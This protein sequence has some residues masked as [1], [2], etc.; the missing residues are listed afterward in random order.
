M[1]FE[2][3]RV[4]NLILFNI[5]NIN[6]AFNLSRK[7]DLYLFKPYYLILTSVTQKVGDAGW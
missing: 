3:S 6:Q 1:D 5:Q 4:K 2:I 7:I